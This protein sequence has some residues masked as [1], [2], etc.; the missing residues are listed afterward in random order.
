MTR[1]RFLRDAEAELVETA[2][3]SDEGTPGLGAEFLDEV[4][5]ALHMAATHPSIGRSVLGDY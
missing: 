4:E 2:R 3:Y 1:Q 5:R